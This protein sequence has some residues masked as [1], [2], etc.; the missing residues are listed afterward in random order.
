MAKGN[1]DIYAATR[2]HLQSTVLSERSHIQNATYCSHPFTWHS[3]KGNQQ[4]QKSD[5]WHG[6]HARLPRSLGELSRLMETFYSSTVLVTRLCLSKHTEPYSKERWIYCHYTSL[7]MIFEKDKR[8]SP[9]H[10]KGT[11]RRYR[12]LKACWH[13]T[14]PK[15]LTFNSMSF[16]DMLY[17]L[18]TL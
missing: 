4:G 16:W 9:C 3:G 11:A 12:K 8:K 13:S 1:N 6:R 5:R 7:N 2:M 18:K 15:S 14:V 17:T 10:K